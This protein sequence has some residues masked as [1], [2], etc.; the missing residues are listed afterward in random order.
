MRVAVVGGGP[1]GLCTALELARAGAEMVV[2]DRGEPDGGAAM[3]N[4]G[5]VVPPLSGPGVVLGTARATL[6]GDGSVLLGGLP[7]AGLLRWCAGFLREGT[8]S[9][10]RAGIRALLGL[11]TLA[12][13]RFEALRESGVDFETHQAGLLLAARTR[14][15]CTRRSSSPSPPATPATAAGTRFI[16]GRPCE[17]WSRRS[18]PGPS[19]GCAC[20]TRHTCG[21]RRSWPDCAPGSCEVLGVEPAP[22]GWRVATHTGAVRADRVVLA[23]GT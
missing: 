14:P 8:A 20:A 13:E 16:G 22:D 9:R 17:R 19:A 11:G 12:V 4:A 7:S 18:V 3:A 23:A 15:A 21:R 2:L 1:V 6:R 10:H 5:W